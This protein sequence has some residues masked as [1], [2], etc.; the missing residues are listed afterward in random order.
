[1][2]KLKTLAAII[3]ISLSTLSCVSEESFEKEAV[4]DFETSTLTFLNSKRPPEI[5]E[6]VCTLQ[7]TPGTTEHW[8][9]Y[10]DGDTY[11][12]IDP[13]GDVEEIDKDN[14]DTHCEDSV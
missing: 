11:W 5:L 12:L 14:A 8:H 13:N 6:H 10:T 9:I 3:L 2:N 4:F 7:P 1:M